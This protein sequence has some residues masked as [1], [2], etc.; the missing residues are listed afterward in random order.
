MDYWSKKLV[1]YKINLIYI[2]LKSLKIKFIYRIKL[3]LV[4][5]LISKKENS[6]FININ[7]YWFYI[8]KIKNGFFILFINVKNFFIQSKK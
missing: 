3:K 7:S 4:L 5:I 8:L 1:F 6:K 2:E